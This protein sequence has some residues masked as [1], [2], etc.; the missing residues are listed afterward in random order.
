MSW[1]GAR[2]GAGR[3][4]RGPVPSEPHKTRPAL[5]ARHPVHVIA[6]FATPTPA[7]P[8]TRFP[9]RTG[10]ARS[11]RTGPAPSAR[12]GPAPSERTG[13]APSARTGPAPS[14]RTGP[15]PSERTGPAPSER[16]APTFAR[17]APPAFARSDTYRALRRALTVSLARSDFRIVHFAVRRDR[18]ELV[19]EADDKHALARGMQG[20]QVSAAKWLNRFA[21]RRGTVF[22]DRYRSRIL[23]TRTDVRALVGSISAARTSAWPQTWLLRIELSRPARSSRRAVR[24]WIRSRADEDS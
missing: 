20:F 1:G 21:R 9:A 2:V 18:L 8:R 6:R 24:R 17:T 3:P 12:T 7:A 11:A 16:T 15:A 22:A 14:A 19:V 5:A 10:P 4:A 23:K 13:P